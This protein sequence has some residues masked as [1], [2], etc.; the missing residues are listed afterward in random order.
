MNWP[1]RCSS[2][3]CRACSW[4]RVAILT[5]HSGEDRRVKHAFREVFAERHL[6]PIADDVIWADMRNVARIRRRLRNCDGRSAPDE[7]AMN[8]YMAQPP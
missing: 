2:A 7:R 6:L 1:C 4:G 5:F 8:L 3:T